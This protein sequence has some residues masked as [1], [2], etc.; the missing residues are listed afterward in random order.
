MPKLVFVSPDSY[1]TEI[2]VPA[3]TSVMQA[4][5]NANITGIA[6]ECGGACVCATCHVYVAHT[7][8]SLLDPSSPDEQD[9]L[10]GVAAELRPESRL[11]CQIKIT[12]ARDGLVVTVPD[13]QF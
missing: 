5:I 1:R 13:R 12:A 9:M 10:D 2:E 6:A 8:L 4:A 7:Q 11:S 3:G